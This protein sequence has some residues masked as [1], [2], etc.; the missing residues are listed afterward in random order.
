MLLLAEFN[1]E[2][3]K[4]CIRE[5]KPANLQPCIHEGEEQTEWCCHQP[6][7]NTICAKVNIDCSASWNNCQTSYT[8]SCS[9][10]NSCYSTSP[11]WHRSLLVQVPAGIDPCWYRSLLVQVPTGIG[12]C[13]HRSLL[14][15]VP[16]RTLLDCTTKP[17]LHYCT[18]ERPCEKC[19]RQS[20]SKYWVLL[21]YS[22]H[23]CDI[24]HHH[25]ALN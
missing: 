13:W 22:V 6:R 2:G 5:V 23:Q 25:S 17:D 7:A 16:V 18:L 3:R 14:V 4:P 19:R 24:I 12:P 21:H 20:S 11:C 10:V 1:Q 9:G 15:Q 8:Q